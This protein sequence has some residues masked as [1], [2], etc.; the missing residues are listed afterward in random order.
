MSIDFS[1]LASQLLSS[2]RTLLPT[3]FPAGKFRGHEFVVGDL[4]GE[5]GDSLSINVNT[6]KWCDFSTGEKGGDLVSLFAAIHKISQAEAAKQLGGAVTP[7]PPLKSKS[8]ADHRQVVAPVPNGTPTCPCRHYKYGNPVAVWDYRDAEGRLLG[9]VARYEP[10]GDRKQIVPFTYDGKRWGM[11]SW[12]APRPLYGLDDLAVRKDAP[13]LIVEGE[14]SADAARKISPQYVVI[15]WPGG[16]RAWQKADFGP[17]AG[18]TVL[19]WPD[20]DEP[21]IKAMWEIG[22]SLLKTCATVKI[23]IPDQKPDGWDAADALKEG[24]TWEKFKEWAKA[25]VHVVTEASSKAAAKPKAN[26]PTDDT[27]AGPGVPVAAMSD[28]GEPA[29]SQVSRWIAWNLDR[30]GNGLPHANLNNAV[31][32]LENDPT[33]KNLVWYDEFLQRILTQYKRGDDVLEPREWTDADDVHLALYMQ[34]NVGL[35]KLGRD[36]VSQAVIAVAFRHVRNCVRDWLDALEWDRISR[37]DHFFEDHFGAEAT[38]YT[39]AAACNFWISMVARV[40][41]PG[42]KV[43]NMVVLEGEQ[44]IRKSSALQVIGGQWFTEQHESVTGKGFF[45]VLQGKLLV[46]IG[47]MDSFSRADITRVKQV[48]TCPSDR[49][50]ESYGRY[51]KD[52]PRQ[53]VFVGTTNKDDWNK[54]ETGARRF[55][56]I[57]CRGDIDI[58]AIRTNRDQLFAEAVS[59]FRASEDWWRMPEEET[60]AEQQKRYDTDPWIDFIYEFISLRT[61]VTVPEIL[62]D[63][64]KFDKDRIGKPDQMRVASCLRVIG[65]KRRLE[66]SVGKVAKV[67][68]PA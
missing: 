38:A 44:G 62:I 48:V 17:I 36:I 45:E 59:R 13:V 14:K 40:Y 22:H 43:D 7:T 42:C 15:T 57:A 33:L 19:L 18:R 52:H 47:E 27:G 61:D 28:G 34:R 2:A 39:R 66:R 25:R 20:A 35:V 67:W 31:I 50:R 5:Q 60:R 64:L 11:G 37:I 56:P 3:W 10:A 9:H 24:W 6:G 26:A 41:M 32:A 68:R 29:Q 4:S 58:D 63:C 51:A 54:D 12:P 65:W 55:W 30:A 49:F 46:E 53:C 8:S 16:A 1:G 21:G 23:L